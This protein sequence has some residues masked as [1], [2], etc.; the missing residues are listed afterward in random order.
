MWGMEHSPLGSE[1]VQPL[2]GQ[3]VAQTRMLSEGDT[4]APYGQGVFLRD[5][6]TYGW[7][8]STLVF[9]GYC[10]PEVELKWL[11][12]RELAVDCEVT[13][14]VPKVLPAPKGVVVTVQRSGS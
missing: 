10:K 4:A 12:A 1:S 14:G 3:Y 11:S 5:R 6:Q 7:S 13:E 8:T 9:A 2:S